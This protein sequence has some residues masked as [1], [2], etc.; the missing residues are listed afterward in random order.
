M[1]NVGPYGN[2]QPSVQVTCDA[3]RKNAHPIHSDT[4]GVHARR[5][6][7]MLQDAPAGPRDER[8]ARHDEQQGG[9]EPAGRRHPLGTELAHVQVA[10]MVSRAAQ[11]MTNAATTARHPMIAAANSNRLMTERVTDA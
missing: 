6:G 8:A 5:T 9:A 1:L 7:A 11:M 2:G 10:G 3:K 4:A